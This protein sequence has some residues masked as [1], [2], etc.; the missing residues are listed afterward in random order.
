[1]V[2]LLNAK[3]LLN[4]NIIVYQILES[5]IIILSVFKI[6]FGEKCTSR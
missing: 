2:S 6:S 1:M 4:Q 5:K 3:A